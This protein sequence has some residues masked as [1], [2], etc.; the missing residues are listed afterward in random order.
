MSRF[1]TPDRLFL[2][3]VL[4][5]HGLLAAWPPLSDDPVAALAQEILP[6]VQVTLLTLWVLI[7][8]GHWGIRLLGIPLVA[9]CLW[10]WSQVTGYWPGQEILPLGLWVIAAAGLAGLAIRLA[11]PRVLRADLV[12]DSQNRPMQFSIRTL[13][14]VTTLCCLLLMGAKWV[15][16]TVKIEGGASLYDDVELSPHLARGSLAA[17]LVAVSLIALVAVLGTRRP[18]LSSLLLIPVAVAVGAALALVLHRQND[19]VSLCL[20][21]V[22]QSLLVAGS[23][24]PLRNLGYRLRRIAKSSSAARITRA[25]ALESFQVNHESVTATP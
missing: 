14:I 2:A 19:W 23:L 3:T 8:P 10:G 24:A 22:A 16:A 5:G 18:W 17:G 13:L 12:S 4:A 15:H 7:G 21:M 11:G 25:I 9:G 1:F 6:F 20:W